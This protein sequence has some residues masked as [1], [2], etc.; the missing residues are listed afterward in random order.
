MKKMFNF[1]FLFL[2]LFI[3]TAC[4][5][6]G[7]VTDESGQAIANAKV[8]A[9]YNGGTQS[10]LT[11]TN[12]TYNI[13]DLPDSGTVTLTVTKEGYAS[14]TK[15]T[16]LD[17]SA[18]TLN[19]ELIKDQDTGSETSINVT[20]KS[21]DG[22]LL[23]QAS[24]SIGDVTGLTNE[25]GQVNLDV[26]LSEEVVVRVSSQGF[27]NQSVVTPITEL[28]ELQVIML[29]VK[30][31]HA[32]T[33]IQEAQVIKGNTLNA[34]ITISA[35]A[36][37][38][39]NGTPAEG[40]VT[41][42][43]TPWD[44][45]DNDLNAMLG[46][47]QALD[48]QNERVELISAGMMSV[49]FY[50]A[51]GNYLQLA[52]NTTAQIQMDLPYD[53]INNEPLAV[54]STIPLW[55][56]DEATG[57]W[58][59]EGTGTVVASTTSDTGLA[60]QADVPHFSTW[61]WDFKFENAGSVNV[62]CQNFDGS[63][64]TCNV[65]ANITLDDGSRFTKSNNLPLEGHTVI[66]MPTSGS[67]LW[68]AS[69]N[70]LIGTQTSGT[71]GNVV[72]T[73]EEPTTSNFVQCKINGEGAACTLTVKTQGNASL[74]FSIPAQGATV[75]TVLNGVN[76]IT[77][78]A[79]SF[80]L[81]EGQTFVYYTGSTVSD[82][83]ESISINLDNRIEIGAKANSVS[84]ACVNG[85]GY[86]VTACNINVHDNREVGFY[87]TFENVPVGDYVT[88]DL[89]DDLRPDSI[90]NFQVYDSNNFGLSFGYQ[91]FEYDTL[92]D[93]QVIDVEINSDA[94]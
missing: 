22:A 10:T 90:M 18:V 45:Q 85:Q 91:N 39:T 82:T 12:G 16:E 24:V 38:D 94:V 37:V 78:E 8:I 41:L 34:K 50:D 11:G 63:A 36:F 89:P 55:H 52:E 79:R 56:F 33:N 6:D 23:N 75:S 21:Q 26:S 71:T 44:I 92:I 66:N 27:V 83:S 2:G 13:E 80:N 60:V 25:E 62:R 5:V 46:N 65:T 47:G 70:G 19:F 61:N 17:R 43:L 84:V 53:S 4:S 32:I 51:Q 28:T 3:L 77:W 30:E 14:S 54:G 7:T 93:G 87:V 69:K 1:I 67:I 29:P 57:L 72:I 40:N 59:E 48:A 68:K 88:V 49:S 86:N 20:V 64:T 9:V 15:A 31:V 58:L 76:S 35:N 42:N 81:I 73:L 74:E